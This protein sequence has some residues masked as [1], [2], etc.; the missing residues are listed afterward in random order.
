MAS[1]KWLR[2]DIEKIASEVSMWWRRAKFDVLYIDQ[3]VGEHL[4]ND[5][6]VLGVPVKI[7]NTQ[8]NLRDVTGIKRGE[9]M[10]MMEQ[11]QYTIQLN[12]EHRILFPKNPSKDMQE[13]IDQVKVFSE[14]KTEEGSMAWR[15]PG[16]DLDDLVKALIT[17]C[18]SVRRLI[19]VGVDSS[20]VGGQ[21]YKEPPRFQD[22]NP[23]YEET[24][25]IDSLLSD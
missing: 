17:A 20:H 23:L 25:I 7:I 18:F 19:M 9:I 2:L 24:K 15:A 8:K 21:Y 5:I 6:K 13:A 12:Q 3:F 1:P 14:H 10:D 16:E 11:V 22:G 4:I